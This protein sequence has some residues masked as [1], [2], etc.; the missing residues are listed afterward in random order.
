MCFLSEFHWCK[1]SHWPWKRQGHFT[2][3]RCRW[4]NPQKSPALPWKMGHIWKSGLPT[5]ASFLLP[6]V[7]WLIFLFLFCCFH[8]LFLIGTFLSLENSPEKMPAFFPDSINRIL[9]L[10]NYFLLLLQD[11]GD[12][13][14]SQILTSF[15]SKSCSCLIGLWL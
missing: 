9:Q 8:L 1:N 12:K 2:K 13:K 7:L 6:Q 10:P 4:G 3:W 15:A 14:Y 5:Q 11:L